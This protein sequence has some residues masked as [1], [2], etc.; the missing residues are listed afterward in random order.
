MRTEVKNL[1]N[2]VLFHCDEGTQ[3]IHRNELL[4]FNSVAELSVLLFAQFERFA[5]GGNTN[6]QGTWLAPV[7]DD[8]GQPC[9]G[10]AVSVE[11]VNEDAQYSS[12]RS[13]VVADLSASVMIHNLSP[14]AVV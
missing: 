12:G 1:R 5:L 2:R 11:D 8:V 3:T 9:G 7:M 10:L 6:S 14:A 13:R 4:V